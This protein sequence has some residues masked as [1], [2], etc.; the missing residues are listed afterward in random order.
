MSRTTPFEAGRKAFIDNNGA[1]P[2]Y[3]GTRSEQEWIE[4]F[5]QAQ[6]EAE[7]AS[8]VPPVVTPDMLTIAQTMLANNSD[9]HETDRG[10]LVN[11]G[12]EVWLCVGESVS[13][14]EL[15]RIELVCCAPGDAK[16]TQ[17]L[18]DAARRLFVT[19]DYLAQTA[20][21]LVVNFNRDGVWL[22]KRGQHDCEG[23][24]PQ[25][26]LLILAGD[27]SNFEE[28]RPSA[29]KISRGIILSQ[30]YEIVTQESAADGDAAERGFD[31]EDSPH[32]FRETVELIKNEGFTVP[33]CSHGVPRWLSTEVIQ[34]RAFFEDGEHR[35]LSLHPS[36]DARSQRY[37]AKACRAAG[38]CE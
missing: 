31:W 5:C 33:S 10:T 15:D 28:V 2:F 23:S 3:P 22:C 1:C 6:T 38:V 9:Y 34:D 25:K 16:I 12:D 21:G 11:F 20:D 36:G 32:T 4:G 18:I 37:W 13:L 8:T 24:I 14:N 26:V 27:G 19:G 17:T 35:T 7:N 30:T 29:P